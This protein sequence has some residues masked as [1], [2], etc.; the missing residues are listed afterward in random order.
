MNI[1]ICYILV[2]TLPKLI[3]SL[4]Q[5]RF[6]KQ[7]SA[8]T[9]YILEKDNFIKAAQYAMIK[10]K[11]SMIETLLDTALIGFWLLFGFR[12]LDSVLELSP[13]LKSV[14][15]VLGFLLLQAL[16]GLPLSAYGTLVVNKRFGFAKGG[17]GLFISDTLKAL[18][19]LLIIGGILIFAFS[20]IIV[21]VL[22][23]EL[24]AFVFGAVL[25]VGL[26]VLY[27]TLIA[28]M[29][30]QFTPLENAELKESI[31]ALLTRV[32][33]KSE[34]VFVMDASK[35][36]GRLNAYFAGLGKAKRVILFDT[37]LDKIPQEGL[38]AVLGH[39]LGH[40]KHHDIYKMMA[41][42]LVF[43]GVLL[44]GIA[45]LP[46]SLFVSVG[47]EAS[48]HAFIVFLLILSA[49]FG[50]YFM[51]VMNGLSCQNE[52]NADKFGASVTSA[53]SLAKALLVLVKENNSFPLAHPLYM[54][55]FYS[56]PPLMA[57]LIALN[58]AHLS[59]QD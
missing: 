36:D 54:R 4:L 41:L 13:L 56:H 46:Q 14:V 33:F 31:N 42:L 57:R 12:V 52:F 26:N 39:E 11:M 10:E 32:G 2:L 47:L 43:F 40:F 9:P 30:N 55:F 18:A 24:Y 59:I 50:F 53:E 15:F 17:V 25:I 34:G 48:P 23:W 3:L 35:R 37:L 58:C 20:W 49:P 28:P 21:N 38:L 29:F 8:K 51:L 45:H 44:F 1:L 6:L 5:L 27:P 19:L 16:V 7:E 22:N